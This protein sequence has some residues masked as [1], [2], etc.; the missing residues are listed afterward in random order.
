MRRLVQHQW[1]HFQALRA[2]DNVD[3]LPVGI[4]EQR[5]SLLLRHATC[6]CNNRIAS[7]LLLQN[8][9]L[10]ETRI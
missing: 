1:Q 6:N 5:L 9:E 7:R 2:D 8:A 10:A 3:D 4:C